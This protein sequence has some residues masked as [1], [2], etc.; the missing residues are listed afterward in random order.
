[1][2][3]STF[4][5]VYAYLVRFFEKTLSLFSVFIANSSLSDFLDAKYTSPKLPFPN[6]L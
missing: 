2:T 6:N 5:S 3:D 1:M 4:F